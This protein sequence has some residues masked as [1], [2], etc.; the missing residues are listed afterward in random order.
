MTEGIPPSGQ[1]MWY[2]RLMSALIL[3]MLGAAVFKG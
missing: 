1:G 2:R 3:T